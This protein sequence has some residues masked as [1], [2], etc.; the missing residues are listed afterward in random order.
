[1]LGL[2]A[3][4]LAVYACSGFYRI[5]PDEV[6]VVL[7][8]GR[9]IERPAPP[10]L[11]Y[12]LPNPIS[13]LHRVKPQAVRRLEFG[14]RTVARR[15]EVVE[16][17]AYLWESF[18]RTGI[19][20]KVEPEA[21]M[22]TGDV[23][24]IDLNWAIEYRVSDHAAPGFLFNLADSE[25]LVRAAVEHTVRAVV[26]RMR[27][28]DILT[29]ARHSIEAAVFRRLQPLLEQYQACV[30]V[31]AVRLQDVHPPIDVVPAFR[32]VAT[33]REDRI[34]SINEA[35]GY[36]NWTLPRSRG[37]AGQILSDGKAY[38]TE[39]QRNAEGDTAYFTQVS[40]AVHDAPDTVAFTM[41]MD[42]LEESLPALR[43]VVL[44][45][46][47]SSDAAGNTLQR[48]FMMG[49]FLK[50]SGVYGERATLWPESEGE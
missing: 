14:Y 35:R 32:R 18:H 37:Y 26:G 16:P 27:L 10:G 46:G 50:N 45:E 44:S 15:G 11:H 34:T 22:L 19:Y 31:T 13:K 41:H 47:L 30:T 23:N 6:G 20:K 40:Q 9:L 48:F 3:L 17:K 5:Q 2:L 38:K 12:R 25:A 8:T 7:R 29:T 43:K 42:C 49:E 33:A 39:K 21:I 28:T 24:E 4:I 36:A 1:M